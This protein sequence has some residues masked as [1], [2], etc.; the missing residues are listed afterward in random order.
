MT[1]RRGVGGRMKKVGG[2]ALADAEQ[3]HSHLMLITSSSPLGA[4]DESWRT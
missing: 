4:R 1:R 2:V 3:E